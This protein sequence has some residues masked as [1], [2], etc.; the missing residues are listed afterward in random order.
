MGDVLC[1]GELLQFRRQEPR[2]PPPGVPLSHARCGLAGDASDHRPGR[3]DPVWPRPGVGRPR[4]LPCIHDAGENRGGHAGRGT[5]LPSSRGRTA[6]RHV[7]RDPAQ[8]D[9][10]WGRVPRLC[11][12][13]GERSRVPAMGEPGGHGESG[14]HG[15]AG[16]GGAR[17]W[18]GVRGR[19]QVR[20]EG[21]RT[22]RGRRDGLIVGRLLVA[23]G[24]I[25]AGGLSDTPHDIGVSVVLFLFRVVNIARCLIFPLPSAISPVPGDDGWK[26]RSFGTYV[27]VLGYA[28]DNL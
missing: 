9:W 23:Q 22:G 27:L 20:C 14:A 13:G 26:I 2:D 19:C 6:A 15:V 28:T 17:G 18:H 12:A 7:L 24:T 21:A 16:G 3:P 8:G 25:R 11:G 1:Q 4:G 10:S 5:I